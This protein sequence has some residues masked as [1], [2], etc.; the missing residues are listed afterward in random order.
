MAPQF[1][2]IIFSPPY[3]SKVQQCCASTVYKNAIFLS[4][5][6]QRGYQIHTAQCGRRRRALQSAAGNQRKQQNNLSKIQGFAFI[7][8][9]QNNPCPHSRVGRG[10]FVMTEVIVYGVYFL[11]IFLFYIEDPAT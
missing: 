8:K 11:S 5:S 6:R 3:L 10:C 4:S 1:L 9:G 2:Q 7:I